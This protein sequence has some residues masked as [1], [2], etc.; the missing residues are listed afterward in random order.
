[1]SANPHAPTGLITT[2]VLT[3]T[4]AMV[5]L[6]GAIR[7]ALNAAEIGP[8][9][10]DILTFEASRKPPRN[11]PA[12][13]AAA[14]DGQA[15]CVLDTA[16]LHRLGGSLVVESRSPRPKRLYR[17]H[18]AGTRSADGAA[19]CGTAADLLLDTE[20]LEMIAMAAGG[21]GAG[22]REL[23]S[24]GLRTSGGTPQR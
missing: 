19:D 21:F 17:L 13:V 15:D 18:W 6:A 14:R 16:V 23:A 20:R 10:G 12:R 4:V 8:Q 7:L 22:R 9:V 11:A 2:A 1:M 3:V 5:G 24:T